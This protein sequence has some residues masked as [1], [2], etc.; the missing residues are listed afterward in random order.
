MKE[1]N[2]TVIFWGFLL[3]IL[4]GKKRPKSKLQRSR[5]IQIWTFGSLVHQINSFQKIIKVEQIFQ[6]NKVV[7]G[8][9]P[10][11]IISPFYSRH[12]ICLIRIW[13]SSFE[14]KWCVFNLVVST[15]KWCSSFLEK[16]FVFQKI[17]FKA[18]V[19]KTFETFTDCHM[20][21]CRSLKWRAILKILSIYAFLEEPML[22][23]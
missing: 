16:V 13:Q 8:K 12:S 19:L 2:C 6:K 5:K 18:K 1:Q 11:F 10:L 15:K 22:C 9:S 4:K 17:C 3:R 21:A 20:K 7:T 23:L 14:W